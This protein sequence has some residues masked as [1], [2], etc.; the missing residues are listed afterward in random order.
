MPCSLIRLALQRA[1][2]FALL[3]CVENSV[4]LSTRMGSTVCVCQRRLATL[5]TL[6][7]ESDRAGQLANC[8]VLTHNTVCL[9]K[10]INKNYFQLFLLLSSYIF[11]VYR[12]YKHYFIW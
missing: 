7:L 6:L 2:S 8:E 9:Y 1:I 5:R 4:A 12:I 11:N 10:E 3:L